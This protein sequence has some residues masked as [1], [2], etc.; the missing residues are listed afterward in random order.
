MTITLEAPA[1]INLWL[2]VGNKRHD[3]Y[4]DIESVMQ[5]VTLTDT[6]TITRNDGGAA[7]HISISCST[8]ELACDESNLCYMAAQAF[9]SRTG[10][11]HYSVAIH[12][13][14]RIPIAAGLAGGSTDAAATL[15]GLDRL[16]GT[17]LTTEE[18]CGIG[19]RIGADVPFCVRRGI[20][21]TRGIG[22][23][24]SPCGRLPDCAILIACEGERVPTPWAYRMVDEMKERTGQETMSVDRF[25]S[26]LSEKRGIEDI[27][28]GMRNIFEDAV[29]PH[30]ER[31]RELFQMM[32]QTGA[33][34]VMMS[35]S[36]PSVFGV[37]RDM[38]S[39]ESAAKKLR[40]NG[41][42]PMICE[43]YYED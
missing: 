30:R 2:D 9:F 3:G 20:S 13:D 39:A 34:R 1:K 36:G 37:Y 6:L 18:L 23:I 19:K 16:Y 15:T 22:E 43:P 38:R 42:H 31:A 10:M 26:L 11:R 8:D 14:K 28:S 7:R 40:E 4:H 17:G 27:A 21:V 35:G 25:T 33:I 29:L 5:T 32:E 12:I 41:I 24:M